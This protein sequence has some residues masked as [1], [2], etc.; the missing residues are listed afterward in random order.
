MGNRAVITTTEK[1]IGI[2][3]HWNG[4][5]D[6]VTAFL[7][8]CELRG[9]RSFPDDYGIARFTQV[10]ANYFGGGLSIG[11]TDNPEGWAE[12]ADNGMYVVDGWNIVQHWDYEYRK[13]DNGKW[14]K[15]D[16]GNCIAEKVNVLGK[17]Y[18]E[19]YDLDEMLMDIDEAQPV[20]DQLGKD[21]LSAEEVDASE[22]KI[23]DTVYYIAHDD[24]V[25]SAKIVGIAPDDYW[26]NGDKSGMPY[27]DMYG[28]DEPQNNPNNYL[29]GKVRRVKKQQEDKTNDNT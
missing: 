4:G 17:E 1:N 29:N 9:F 22:L 16:D 26:C 10:V 6:S 25:R 5:I 21:F 27:M 3:L 24:E 28:G 13:D 19:G 8:Y 20:K 18:H 12:G 2:Y 7:K 11:V 14:V 23:G 15:N